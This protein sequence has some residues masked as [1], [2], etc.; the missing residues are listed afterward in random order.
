MRPPHGKSLSVLSEPVQTADAG[1]VESNAAFAETR[2]RIKRVGKHIRADYLEA[3]CGEASAFFPRLGRFA[4]KLC[5]Y[6]FFYEVT[7][8]TSS[9]KPEMPAAER[10]T[11]DGGRWFFVRYMPVEIENGTEPIEI[12]SVWRFEADQ[13]V[14]VS[15]NGRV[16]LKGKGLAD[17][18][19]QF[20]LMHDEQVVET[21]SS[22]AD[23]SF[24]FSPIE[25]ATPDMEM[26]PDNAF[27][28]SIMQVDGGETRDG[29]TRDGFVSNQSVLLQEQDGKLTAVCGEAPVFRNVYWAEQE[30]VIQGRV[31][32]AGFQLNGLLLDDAVMMPFEFEMFEMV[33]GAEVSAGKVVCGKDGSIRF[34]LKL[35]L[36]DVGLKTYEIRQCAGQ[37]HILMDETAHKFMLNISDNGTG[38]LD[39]EPIYV[40]R[41][42][43]SLQK[44]LDVV[45]R[46]IIFSNRPE[47]ESLRVGL[48][49]S[50]PGPDGWQLFAN[51]LPVLIENA[52]MEKIVTEAETQVIF[53]GL[54]SYDVAGNPIEWSVQPVTGAETEVIAEDGELKDTPYVR[55]GDV[56][57]KATVASESHTDV[58]FAVVLEWSGDGGVHG[59]DP[60]V[61][62]LKDG[63]TS[64]HTLRALPIDEMKTAYYAE[65]LGPG[66]YTAVI[67]P[68]SGYTVQYLCKDGQKRN[69][70]DDGGR[71][72]MIRIPDTGDRQSV[73]LYLGLG[74]AAIALLIV[75]LLVWR[76]KGS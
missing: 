1:G 31:D 37:D 45:V 11:V 69:A 40:G 13:K 46:E 49:E 55:N 48:D 56:V 19:F 75:C 28:Y 26:M 70:A 6:S 32:F 54:P 76:R 57:R 73:E 4:L 66:T 74:G 42:V 67:T 62:L 21:V 68:V 60:E 71:I 65:D 22:H 39:V 44:P 27:E 30:I 72:L 18:A 59:N 14:D 47:S 50:M 41:T 36:E 10:V 7:A 64:G 51:G 2:N 35:T 17:G 63:K 38:G 29:I 16:E 15:L 8:R 25:F 23:G 61:Q 5:L 58:R 53:R 34:P 3:V 52:I 9:I 33:E 20:V 24:S 43:A 12:V